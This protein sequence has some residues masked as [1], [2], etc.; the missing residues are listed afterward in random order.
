MRDAAPA[1]RRYE[2]PC[3][4]PFWARGG[5]A[6]TLLA[7]LLPSPGRRL[8]GEREIVVDLGDGDRL[9]VFARSGT[10]G[11]RVH[12]FHG[13][14]G[15]VSADYMRRTADVMTELG[16]EVWAVNHRGCD[17][18]D[19]A[20]QPYHSGR[21]E[22]MQA[23]LRESRRVGGA[24]VDLIIGFSLS[25]NMALVHASQDW[26]EQPHGIIAI[27]P[28][29]DLHRASI[30]IGRGLN[31]L[32][33][34]RFMWRLKRAVRER[35]QRGRALREYHIPLTLSL[36]E[37]D[38]LFTAPECGFANGLDYYRQCS[39]ATRLAQI[40]VP[41]VILTA[42]DDPFV[43]PE[44]LETAPR[45]PQVFLHIEPTGGHVGYLS[46]HGPTW[47]RWLDGA[48]THYTRELVGCRVPGTTPS[49]STTPH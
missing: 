11:V 42:A 40:A 49:H 16:H 39:S 12:L 9:Q 32:Y 22:D 33:Q 46:H 5:H 37:F 8:D 24:E 2:V 3:R 35:Q 44:T 13:L 30:D 36:L 7:H 4:A 17:N 48:L 47:T 21:S 15:D 26:P 25:A 6:Q 38:D 1:V 23:V 19:L 20:V 18:R 45:S 14:A 43:A 31:R 27:N 28:P 34:A 29:A 10:S 41:T